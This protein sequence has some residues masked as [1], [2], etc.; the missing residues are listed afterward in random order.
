M[1]PFL[2]S[3]L[4][5]LSRE[6]T[7][8][9]QAFDGQFAEIFESVIVYSFAMSI[10]WTLTSLV[11]VF[12]SHRRPAPSNSEAARRYT[13]LIP[14]H[15]E[16]LAALRS[17]QS[18]AGVT[19]QPDEIILIDDGSPQGLR[20]DAAL[21]PNTRVLK[22]NERRGK[23]GAL[24]EALQSVRS[25]IVVCIDADTQVRSHDWRPMLH[26]FNDPI[27]SG[28]TGKIWP[29]AQAGLIN[30]F[31]RLDYLA[32]ISVIKAAE[33]VWGGLLTVSGAFVA[34]RREALCKVGG[35]REDKAAEDIDISWRMQ[36]AGWR[37]AYDNSWTC[38]V[39]MAPTFRALW[40]Q[41]RR[42]SSGLGQA[43]ADHG[44]QALICGARHLP[45]VVV[46][47]ANLVWIAAILIVTGATVHEAYDRLYYLER[48][49]QVQV[50]AQATGR[51]LAPVER[52]LAERV[53]RETHGE[54]LQSELHFE[55]LRRTL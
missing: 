55:A 28:V 21:P 25:E 16:P 51:P 30:R 7:A 45:V 44:P 41:R 49:C 9:Q 27:L 24:N 48:A 26:M 23:A 17:A 2:E 19:P 13:V 8:W 46:S 39:E 36:C 34:Y 3:Y 20:P 52:S 18:L 32:V 54:R 1:N 15:G 14:F 31:Q 29:I 35:F 33:T 4:N 40:R 37:L 10:L 47:V 42:W 12:R 50:L 53:G 5:I 43:L 11:Y 22:L 6:A 38:S